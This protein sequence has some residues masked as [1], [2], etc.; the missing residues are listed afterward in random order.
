MKPLTKKE[1]EKVQSLL[2]RGIA[3]RQVSM[4]WHEYDTEGCEPWLVDHWQTFCSRDFEVITSTD[5]DNQIDITME[6]PDMQRIFKPDII[7]A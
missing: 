1:I 3:N 6:L 5:P 2:E 4:G 7:E